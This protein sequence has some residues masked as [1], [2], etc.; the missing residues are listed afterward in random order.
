MKN[1]FFLCSYIILL[2]TINQLKISLANQYIK[3]LLKI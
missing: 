1:L 2:Y 3:N